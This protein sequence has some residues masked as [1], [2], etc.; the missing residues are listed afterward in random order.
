MPNPAKAKGAALVAWRAETLGTLR[1]ALPIALALLVEVAM[2]VIEFTMA[3]RLGSAAL[4]VAGFGT[5]IVYVPKILAMGALYSIS[6]LGAQAHGAERPDEVANVVR[7]G[8]RLATFLSLPV[9]GFMLL[10]GP[11]LRFYQAGDPDFDIDIGAIER[12][13]WW[14]IPAVPAFLWFQVLRNFVTILNRPGA[15]TIIA[16]LSVPLLVAALWLFMYGSWGAPDLGVPSIGLAIS[17]VAWFQFLAAVLYISR[18]QYFASYR[19]FRALNIHDR[20]LFRD[21]VRVGSPIAG[22]YFFESAM[23]FASTAAM[24]G[25]GKDAL[26][27]HSLV[28]SIG[29]I[30]F[31]I[32]YALGQA[33][34]VRVGHAMGAKN[35]ESA[36]LRGLV[37]IALCQTWMLGAA[38]T[39]WI[40]PG[41]L[42]S[43]Y[44]ALDDPG[45]SRAVFL[46]AEFFAICAVFQLFDGLQ[47]TTLGVLRGFK[48]TKAPMLIAFIGYW[49]L[50][51]GG[52]F[53]LAYGLNLDGVGLWWGLAFGL[54]GSGLMLFV[55][56]LF[57]SKRAIAL[58]HA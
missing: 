38:L 27:A 19:I 31:M 4:A 41:L 50:G 58:A 36:R 13:L 34:T 15:V 7:Q 48:D 5:Q 46:A 32:P 26:A 53:V 52:G 47:T 11:A 40:W 54:M 45:N 16:A 20:R 1:L 14:A 43:F 10:T 12:T 42:T 25:F 49:L 55:R 33:G 3:G 2:G 17:L 44:L 8:F 35:P 6:A 23:F 18:Q 24:A 57:V 9:I 28:F 29:N 37:A 51:I 30:A 21:L 39:M 56:F 22:A